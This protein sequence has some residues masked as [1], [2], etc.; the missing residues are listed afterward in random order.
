MGVSSFI[1]HP[2]SFI[3]LFILAFFCPLYPL[4]QTNHLQLGL[5]VGC[6]K[7]GRQ[8]APGVEPELVFDFVAESQTEGGLVDRSNRI[9]AENGR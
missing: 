2:S 1:S 8:I 7:V 6:A 3:L 9:L 5:G 4:I